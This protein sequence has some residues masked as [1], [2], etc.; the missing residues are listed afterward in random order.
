M[1]TEIHTRIIIRIAVESDLQEL[2]NFIKPFV[3]SRRLLPRT[4]DELRELLAHLFIAELDGRIVGCAA[5]EIYSWKLAEIRSLAVAPE[6]QGKGLGR[7]LTEQLL[8]EAKAAGV[9]KV[10][11]LTNTAAEFFAR[12]FGFALAARQ[13]F[14]AAFNASSEWCLPRCSSA[15]C[16]CLP[17]AQS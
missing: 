6:W 15:V 7:A 16:L 13:Q 5:L 11:L 1:A 4:F 14:D 10:V 17:I 9:Q 12:E 3:E 8:T 2:E